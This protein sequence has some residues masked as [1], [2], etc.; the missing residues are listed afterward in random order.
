MRLAWKDAGLGIDQV[1]DAILV[2][3][4]TRMAKV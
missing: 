2:G 4:M 3:G 1:G